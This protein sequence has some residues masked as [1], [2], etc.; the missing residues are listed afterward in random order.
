MDDLYRFLEGSRGGAVL[1]LG[2]GRKPY[3][4]IYAP[5]FDRCV[6]L[7]VDDSRTGSGRHRRGR[8]RRPDALR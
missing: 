3:Q 6:A 8:P 4:D 5:H 7:D 2:A 1:D